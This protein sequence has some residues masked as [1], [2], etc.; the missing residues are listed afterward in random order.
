[1]VGGF[2]ERADAWYVISYLRGLEESTGT[3]RQG[4]ADPY[5]AVLDEAPDTTS[6]HLL[7][8]SQAKAEWLLPGGSYDGQ[9]FSSESEVN[10]AN[11]AKLSV[12]WI[13]QFPSTDAPNESTPIVAGNYMYVAAPPGNVYALDVRT[14]KQVWHYSRPIPSDIRVCCLATTRGVAVLGTTVFFGTLDAHMIA[15]D[16]STGKVRWDR[17]VADYTEGYSIISA[18]LPVADLVVTGVGGGEFPTQGFIV[19]YEPLTGKIRWRFDTVPK[20]DQPAVK[21]WDA[22]TLKAGAPTWGVGAYDPELNLLYWGVG[23]AAPDFNGAVRPGDNL[24]SNCLLAL[25]PATGKLAWYFQYLPGDDDHDW[26]SI[27][28]PSLIDIE[29]DGVVQKWL[30]VAHRNGFF[31]VLDRKT[32]K[33]VRGAPFAK[34]TWATGLDPATGHAIRGPNT[35]GTP[36]GTFLY[37]SLNGATNWWPSAYSPLTHLYYVNVEEGGGLYYQGP[38]KAKRGRLYLGG[39]ATFG[40]DSFSDWVRAIDPLTA[41][42]RWER[43]NDTVTSAPRGGLLTTAG[44]LLVGSDGA[45]L[46]AL[47]ADSGKELW[48]FNAGGHISAPPITF[49]IGERQMISVLSGQDVL[50][51]ALASPEAPDK[52]PVTPP[53]QAT[54]PLANQAAPHAPAA[55]VSHAPSAKAVHKAAWRRHRKGVEPDTANPE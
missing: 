43:R 33:F 13:H 51:F 19:A 35:R 3:R 14:G 37:P 31:Y 1:M 2:I 4:F 34:Q 26:D 39:N 42:V 16:A 46:Y 8:S 40:N 29:Q 53:D 45:R 30:V 52:V 25:D 15:L 9:R 21:T 36:E 6:A 27:Q 17:Q 54:V 18:P 12:Q 10:A 23:S 28:T 47:D 50:T 20:L 44:G 32:G 24:Y 38:A 22:G 48:S 41:Q 7:E 49:R 5:T 55:A 11:V